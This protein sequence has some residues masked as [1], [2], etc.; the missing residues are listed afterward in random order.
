MMV[1]LQAMTNPLE[2]LWSTTWSLRA[3]RCSPDDD[4]R[5]A[6]LGILLFWGFIT[7]YFLGFRVA[8]TFCTD[9]CRHADTSRIFR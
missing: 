3:Y 1:F 4:S 6:E 9:F 7:V 2:Q 8:L 5:S